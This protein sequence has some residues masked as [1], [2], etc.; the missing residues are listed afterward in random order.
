MSVINSQV[1][2]VNKLKLQSTRM[3]ITPINNNL[4]DGEVILKVDKFALTANNISYGIAGD[5]LGY[6]RFFPVQDE[7]WGRLPVMGFADVIFSN[8]EG[9]EV[10]ERVWGFM[11]MATH[12]KISAGKVSPTNFSDVSSYRADLSP[13]YASFERVSKNPFYQSKNEDFE[14]LVRGLYTTAWLI[15]DFMF[16][17]QYFDA[18][19]Y[20]ITSASSKT[21]IALAFAI[22]E[23]GERPAIGITSK[24]NQA[25]VESLQCY[26]QVISYDD[27]E[28]LDPNIPSMIVDMAGS[29]TV[30]SLIHHHFSEQLRYSCRVGLTHHDD[31]V[32]EERLPGAKPIFFF[33]PNQLKKR[34]VEFGTAETMKKMGISLLSYIEFC[35]SR[36]TIE[37]TLD[38]NKIDAI[39]QNVLSGKADASIGLIISL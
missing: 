25:F 18:K 39:Y 28:S 33:A 11:P 2:E 26:E 5:S 10:G 30:L 36:M 21:S 35:R 3:S 31:I 6:W 16:D 7:Q 22:Q 20:I 38:K 29:Q 32:T 1:F 14:I 15:D 8:C 37:H 4:V 9:V 24:V 27:I 23:R 13:F 17:N 19:Q 34:T 12:F